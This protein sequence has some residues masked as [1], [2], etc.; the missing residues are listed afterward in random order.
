VVILSRWC[1]WCCILP[2]AAGQP[3]PWSA[4]AVSG[5]VGQPLIWCGFSLFFDCVKLYVV[6]VCPSGVHTWGGLPTGCGQVVGKNALSPGKRPIPIP[7]ILRFYSK[8]WGIW[9]NFEG[10][11]LILRPRSPLIYAHSR[12]LLGIC[13]C[14]RTPT[15]ILRS[16]AKLGIYTPL[17]H[18]NGVQRGVSV[19]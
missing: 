17:R 18:Y 1:W 12:K 13:A 5:G 4:V 11:P 6:V 14:S 2:R 10:S 9:A 16:H 8:T 7:L 3:W 19:C 15:P